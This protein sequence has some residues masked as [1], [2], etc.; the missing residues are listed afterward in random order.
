MVDDAT[1]RKFAQLAK[2]CAKTS[3]E[4]LENVEKFLDVL[5]NGMQ[6]VEGISLLDVKNREMV[7]YMAEISLLMSHMSC[8]KSI[9]D[10]PAVF[11]ASKHRTVGSIFFCSPSTSS[12]YNFDDDDNES[13]E[14]E[15]QEEDEKKPKKYVPP[16]MMAVRYDEDENEK[17]AK[18]M[19]K[20]KRRA[21]QSSLVQELRQQYSDAPEE[22][23]EK[24][25]KRFEAEKERERYEE[26]NFIRLRMSKAE[27]K[28]EQRMNR[29]NVM[30]DLF[31]FG[32]YM[33]RDESGEA[34]SKS[35]KRS[36][37]PTDRRIERKKIARGQKENPQVE[38]EVK[39]N[40]ILFFLYFLRIFNIVELF[41]E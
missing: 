26:D 11:R 18:A 34:L 30:D 2:E 28:R 20:A 15:G 41:S 3:S 39:G 37:N 6:D 10:H 29:E 35:R 4:A 33:M 24:S 8:G 32:N 14:D 36:K 27:K 5:K 22:Y 38:S 21:L 23:R 16:K 12:F 31:N 1:T 13:E 19:E 40:S 9:K 7:C 25:R 17:E